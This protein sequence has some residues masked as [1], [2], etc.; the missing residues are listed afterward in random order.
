L[1]REALTREALTREALTR[2]AL[3]REALTREA[4]TQEALTEEAWSRR[5]GHPRWHRRSP[6]SD[7]AAYIHGAIVPV[8]GGA[9]A[10]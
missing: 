10:A 1:T 4:L 9:T 6:A 5:Q 8:D 7:D 3:T 2:E